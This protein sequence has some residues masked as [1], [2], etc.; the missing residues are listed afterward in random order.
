MERERQDIL[1]AL[2]QGGYRQSD[3]VEP[4]EE[5]FAEEPGPDG[6]LQGTIGAAMMRTSARRSLAS[7][8]RS[9]D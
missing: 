6:R 8:S 3:D 1:L 5:I 2:P 4:E 9:Y 7:P